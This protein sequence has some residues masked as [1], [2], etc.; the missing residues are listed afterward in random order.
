MVDNPRIPYPISGIPE[1][2]PGGGGG[3]SVFDSPDALAINRARLA[4]LDSLGLPIR[5]KSVLDVGCGVGH[6]SR[7]FVERGCQVTCVD[8]RAEN[9][10]SLR[11]RYPNMNAHVADVHTDPLAAFGHFDIV[12]CYGLLYHLENPVSGLRNMAQVCNEL[13]LLETVITD[14]SEPIMRLLDEPAETHNQ[15]LGGM[16]CRPT[17]AFVAMALNRAGFRYIYAPKY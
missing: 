3:I 16:A 9:I 14:H 5:G 11:E 4:H 7:F 6:L 15:A 8:G 10:A 13:L 2:P 1:H 17:P 12:F